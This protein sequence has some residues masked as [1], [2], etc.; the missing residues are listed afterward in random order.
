M[1]ALLSSPE[2]WREEEARLVFTVESSVE[3]WGE[4]KQRKPS[5]YQLQ[6]TNQNEEPLMMTTCG[7]AK[8]QKTNRIFD[9][10]CSQKILCPRDI[11]S[12]NGKLKT[13]KHRERHT[14]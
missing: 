3:F 1:D 5:L 8:V 10:P 2:M 9:R 4:N 6:P 13:T 11:N 14:K 12:C 7:E